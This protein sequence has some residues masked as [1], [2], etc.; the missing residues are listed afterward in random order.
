[1][2]PRQPETIAVHPLLVTPAVINAPVSEPIFQGSARSSASLDQ[3][4][5]VFSGEA[6]GVPHPSNGTAHHPLLESLLAELA[7]RGERRHGCFRRER[8]LEENDR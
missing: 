3:A 4:E 8:D 1:V 5:A 7:T 6:V 2:A